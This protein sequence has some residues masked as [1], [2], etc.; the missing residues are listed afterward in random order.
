[1][2]STPVQTS[3]SCTRQVKNAG[4]PLLARIWRSGLPLY[5]S[6]VTGFTAF[7]ALGQTVPPVILSQTG[8]AS[9]LAISGAGNFVVRD[10]VEGLTLV[11]RS[12]QFT[13]EVNGYLVNLLGMRVQ[14]FAD[15]GMT[16]FG[17][18]KIDSAGS[19]S[20]AQIVTYNIRKDGTILV[21]LNDG[22]QF[23]RG[24]ILLQNFLDPQNLGRL[25]YGLFS[26]S[27]A[28]APLPQ[29]AA[30]G[31]GGLGTL[32]AGEI[33]IP[34]PSLTLGRTPPPSAGFTPGILTG[35]PIPTDLAVAGNGFFVVRDTNSNELYATRAGAFYLDAIGRL[36]NYAGMPVQGYSNADNNS[37]GDI[38]INTNTDDELDPDVVMESFN[39]SWTGTISIYLSDGSSF[40]RGQILLADCS[41]PDLLAR[42]NFGLYA[43]TP[44]AGPWT[45]LSAPASTNL[46][47]VIAG[48]A[49]LNQYDQSILDVRQRL[50]LFLQGP[51]ALASSPADLAILGQGF[52]TVRDPI[53]NALY[54]TRNGAF[55]LDGVARLVD[56]NGFRVQGLNNVAQT[57]TGDITID[58][59]GDPYTSNSN[60]TVV[61]FN[62]NV[63]GEI[64]VL[65]SD[66]NQFVRGQ[67]LLQNFQNLQALTRTKS[68]LF[69]FNGGAANASGWIAHRAGIGILGIRRSGN[70]RHDPNTPTPAANWL[71]AARIES[72]PH[73]HC[74]RLQRSAFLDQ[75]RAGLRFRHV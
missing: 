31:A 69:Q 67:I 38:E 53:E 32:L 34:I 36:I 54:A 66:G 63:S 40:N 11:T 6:I 15:T 44:L 72:G 46:G 75:S 41:H 14:G 73:G 4:K 74:A 61:S 52:F 39:I 23:V 17:D 12:G 26:F 8:I 62:I 10:P 48:T 51:I 59:M 16:Q 20:T 42:T 35:T 5:W 19:G 57:T 2:Y 22:T 21:T 43:M 65:D 29:P 30:P 27:P 13:L 55:H 25:P 18:I 64:V 9:S 7:T 47:W 71:P 49:E 70:T 58:T 28:A 1:M 60:V 50:N 33:E 37:I 45:P 68:T 3:N 24:Q 56:T